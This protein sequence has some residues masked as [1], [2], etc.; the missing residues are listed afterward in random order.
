MPGSDGLLER[1]RTSGALTLRSERLGTPPASLFFGGRSSQ[2]YFATVPI[3]RSRT[4]ATGGFVQGGWGL[5][6]DAGGY[7]RFLGEGSQGGLGALVLG[8]PGASR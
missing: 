7:Q 3:W 6:I 4:G 8:A 1:L 2:S 5:A